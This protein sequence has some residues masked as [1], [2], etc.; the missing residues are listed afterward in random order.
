M[1]C[2]SLHRSQSIVIDGHI[3]VTVVEIRGDKVRLGID[4]PKDVS[5]NRK[6]VEDAIR[7]DGSTRRPRPDAEAIGGK[8]A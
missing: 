1:L 2:L 7:R 8:E 6:E 3:V 5:V 4:A